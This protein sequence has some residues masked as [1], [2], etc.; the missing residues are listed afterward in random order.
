MS[1]DRKAYFSSSYSVSKRFNGL[2]REARMAGYVPDSAPIAPP[3]SGARKA[4]A[5]SNTG[6]HVSQ[7]ETAT[8][9]LTA[10]I[11]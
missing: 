11:G 1:L 4:A 8:T 2:L 5:G 9:V 6:V 10:Q 7:A 3:I